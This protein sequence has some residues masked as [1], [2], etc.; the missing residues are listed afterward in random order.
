MQRS[1]LLFAC[2]ALGACSKPRPTTSSP[3]DVAS[4]SS[5][6]QSAAPEPEQVAAAKVSDELP[7]VQVRLLD[8]GQVPR[9]KLRFTPN[10]GRTIQL[11][12]S[13]DTMTSTF[14][15]DRK[16]AQTHSPTIVRTIRA[17]VLEA[18]SGAFKVQFEGKDSAKSVPQV[19]PKELEK[20]QE[21]YSAQGSVQGVLT[22]DDRGQRLASEFSQGAKDRQV[23]AAVSLIPWPEQE[24]GVGARWE[25]L[26]TA[27]IDGIECR[28]SSIYT[29]KSI[30]KDTVKLGFE[31]VVTGKPGP[32]T[33]P[34]LPPNMELELVSL[35]LTLQGDYQRG[36]SGFYEEKGGYLGKRDLKMKI[37]AQGKVQEIR[38]ES[39]I[40]SK[41]EFSVE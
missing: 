27:S 23:Q 30:E 2:L 34:D 25:S 31:S 26:M 6:A 18:A 24:V 10:V 17:K 40:T 8:A 29:V 20:M 14:V 38:T 35:K 5:Q 21:R 28:I 16:V 15:G 13:T 12:Q 1:L 41:G 22:F 9:K 3:A 7:E 39:E 32:F 19:N 4:S 36:L 11:I 33:S 37:K